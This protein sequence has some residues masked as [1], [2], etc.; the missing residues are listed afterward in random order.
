MRSRTLL[1]AGVGAAVIALAG[2]SPT[3]IS[4]SAAPQGAGAPAA[5]S[6]GERIST[7]ADLGAVVQ[8]NASAKNSVHVQMTMSI[9]GAGGIDASG[10]MKFA[11]ARSAVRM[12]MTLPSLGDMQMVMVEGTVYLKL[13]SDLAGMMGAGSTKPWVKVDL[14]ASDPTAKSL[15]SAADLAGQSD[16]SA[17]IEQIKSAGTITKVTQEQI[18][19]EQTTHYAITVDAKKL[20]GTMPSDDTQKQALSALGVTTIPFDVWV[21]SADLPVRVVTRIAYPDPTG[22]QSQEVAMTANYTHW[23]QPVSITAPPADQVGT[24]GG[25]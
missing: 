4:G 5:S 16:P 14:D 20:A 9:P 2:C 22:G 25:H 13:P 3:S 1:V 24:F 23:G 18:D 17:L 21:D 12:T 8:H 19:G 15:G 10:D 6:S 11:G 7:V